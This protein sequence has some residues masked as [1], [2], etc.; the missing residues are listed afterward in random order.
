MIASFGIAA[1]VVLPFAASAKTP[2][3]IHTLV[4]ETLVSALELLLAEGGSTP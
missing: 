2:H 4:Y 1:A 3:R